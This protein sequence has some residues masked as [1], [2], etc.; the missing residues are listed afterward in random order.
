VSRA[1]LRVRQPG[2]LTC[3]RCPAVTS[4]L[5]AVLEAYH[6]PEAVWWGAFALSPVMRSPGAISGP[7]LGHH[8]GSCILSSSVPSWTRWSPLT[9]GAGCLSLDAGTI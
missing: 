3:A 6:N 4:A 9:A 8:R 1:D 2:A 7:D 5:H